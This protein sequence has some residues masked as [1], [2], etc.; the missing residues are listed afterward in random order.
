MYALYIGGRASGPWLDRE[1]KT[2]RML[3]DFPRL[4]SRT[5]NF[6]LGRPHRFTVGPDGK[7][8]VFLR[9]LGGE[10]PVRRLWCLDLA[11]GE[12]RLLADPGAPAAGAVRSAAERARRE[13]ARD[14]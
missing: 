8:L 11:T 12:E 9:S 14:R 5:Q 7:R 3:V 4:V 1:S 13:R 6:A 2:C 10:D